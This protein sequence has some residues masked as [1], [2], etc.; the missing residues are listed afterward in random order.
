[1]VC[2]FALLAPGLALAMKPPLQPLDVF[3]LQWVSDPQVSP[4]GRTIAYVRMSY[5]I[6]ADKPRGAIWL[7][8]SDGAHAR[9][10]TSA[11]SSVSPRWS[12]DGRRLAYLGMAADGSPQLF[13]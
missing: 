13:M 12:P 1:V 11:T 4:D 8:G 9:P 7:A 10:L 3:D 6:K 5:D 2:L